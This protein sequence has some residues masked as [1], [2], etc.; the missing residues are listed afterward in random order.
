MF[1]CFSMFKTC[2]SSNTVFKNID[3]YLFEWIFN[4][5]WYSFQEIMKKTI[6]L[7]MR[8]LVP[9]ETYNSKAFQKNT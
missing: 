8:E 6:V 1:S 9:K 7:D 5:I 4:M 3:T 2:V